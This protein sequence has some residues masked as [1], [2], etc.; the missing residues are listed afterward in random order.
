MTHRGETAGAIQLVQAGQMDYAEAWALQRGLAA[1]RRA[2]A[3]DDL[4]LLLQHPPTY[5]VGRRG[6]RRNLL[7]DDAT[8]A[9]IGAT[10]Y[11]V[12]RGG[13]ITFHGPGQ[14][15]GYVIMDLGGAQR[16]VRRFVERLERIVIDTLAAFGVTGQIEPAHPGVWVDRDKIAALGIAVRRGVTYHGF[17]LNVDPDLRYFAYMIPCGIPD[18]GATSLARELQ[19]PVRLAEVLPPLIEAVQ[20]TFAREVRRDL[21]LDDLRQI[22]G[23]AAAVQAAG[24]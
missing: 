22:A 20:A 4:L 6:T 18:R 17:A 15:V 12:D 3:V 2:G 21:T 7:I 1:A 9:A 23:R 10:C 13:D 19:R 5:T 16:A 14:L 8:L 24:R 11:A